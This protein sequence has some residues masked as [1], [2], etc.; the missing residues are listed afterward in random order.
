MKPRPTR[1]DVAEKAGVSKTTVT[2]VLSDRQDIA[3]PEITRERVR[4]AAHQLGYQPHAA[5][6]ALASGRT[7]TVTIA[8]PIRICAH[9]AHLLQV[10]ER[11]TNAHDYHMMASTIGHLSVRNVRPDF[12]ALLNNLTDGVILVDTPWAF[13]PAI[14][15]C[16]PA[17]KP[18]VSV[19]AF[20]VPSID[21]VELDLA[22]GAQ[23][24]M[25]H[26]LTSGVERIA[27][28][29]PGIEEEPRVVETFAPSGGA[30]PRFQIYLDVMRS[31]NKPHELISGSIS[32]RLT[33]RDA[34]HNYISRHGCPDALFCFNDELAISAHRTLREMKYR[35]PEDVLLVGCDGS[36]EGEYIEPTLSTIVQPVDQLCSLAWEFMMNRLEN[37][38]LPRQHTVVAAELVVRGSSTR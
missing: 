1:A 12:C 31:A 4:N 17:S 14:E 30:D 11:H 28:F 21:C 18:I 22:G 29:G 7:Q 33:S 8:L 20:T 19:G 26:L 15:T 23:A 38:E 6:K 37:P 24:A 34:L 5:A 25:A 35:I 9:Y 36:E 32:N 10:F 3:I 27:F 2:Y 13:V 16:L